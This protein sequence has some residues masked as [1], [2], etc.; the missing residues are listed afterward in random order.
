MPQLWG[1]LS[2]AQRLFLSGFGKRNEMSSALE[3]QSVHHLCCLFSI[4]CAL[5]EREPEG[6]GKETSSPTS[7]TC[8]RSAPSVFIQSLPPLWLMP[9]FFSYSTSLGVWHTFTVLQVNIYSCN[10][11]VLPYP[12]TL[13]CPVPQLPLGPCCDPGRLLWVFSLLDVTMSHYKSEM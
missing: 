5:S 10:Q 8:P 1:L 9:A 11:V 13:A 12:V 7:R 3:L 4:A 2:L 6:K